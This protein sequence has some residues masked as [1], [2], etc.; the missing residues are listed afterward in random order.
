MKNV[1]TFSGWGQN[2]DALENIAPGAAHINYKD[3][4]SVE[5]LFESLQGIQCD[6]AIGWSLGGQLALRAID[7]DVIEPKR[8]VLISTPF[9]FIAGPGL[10]CGIDVD[11][12]NVFMNDFSHDPVKT[13]KQFSLLIARG[14]KDAKE[15]ARRL[16]NSDKEGAAKWLYWLEQLRSFTCQTMDYNKIPPTLAI[17]GSGDSVIDSSQVDLFRP[18][19]RSGYKAEVLDNCGHAPHLHDEQKVRQLILEAV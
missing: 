10:K 13:L 7:S 17:I 18:L 15:I 4:D 14:D 9:Q 8:L 12:F 19:I 6:I 2:Y 1:V 3:F 16:R 5:A 11:S